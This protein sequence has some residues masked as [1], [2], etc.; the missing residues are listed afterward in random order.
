MLWPWFLGGGSRKLPVVPGRPRC[1]QGLA[2]ELEELPRSRGPA[3][4][5]ANTAAVV[6]APLAR[7]ESGPQGKKPFQLFRRENDFLAARRPG[8]MREAPREHAPK[9]LGPSGIFFLWAI[10]RTDIEGKASG[11][12]LKHF[13]ALRVPA[14]LRGWEQGERAE[15]CRPPHR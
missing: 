14:D 11:T 13:R 5:G 3:V 12:V 15:H 2:W 10:Q 1:Y 6:P 9:V 8:P 7:G 4:L